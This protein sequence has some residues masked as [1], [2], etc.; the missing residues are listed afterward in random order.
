MTFS[1]RTFMIFGKRK[2]PRA[3][4]HP[5]LAARRTSGTARGEAL[6][7]T[8]RPTFRIALP[9]AAAVLVLDQASKFAVQGTISYQETVPVIPG[10]FDLVHVLNKGAA[11]GFLNDASIGW[12]TGFFVVASAAAC[13]LIFWLLATEQG[14]ARFAAPALGLVLGGAL[15]NMVDRVRTGFVVDFLDFY[16]GR[17]HWPAFNVADMGITCGVGLLIVSMYTQGQRG[18]QGRA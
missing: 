9:L 11:F 14:Q 7:G 4:S 16:L 13:A 5:A 6:S 15:G 12:Q 2:S 17:W 10:L 8:V 1:K 18:R 3:A